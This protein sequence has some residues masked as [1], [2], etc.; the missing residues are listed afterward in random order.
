MKLAPKNLCKKLSVI[1]RVGFCKLRRCTCEC[2]S[3]E[4]KKQCEN[5]FEKCLLKT[6]VS[7]IPNAYSFFDRAINSAEKKIQEY[8]DTEDKLKIIGGLVFH[9]ETEILH[10]FFESPGDL[11]STIS[12]VNSYV[13]EDLSKISHSDIKET[14]VALKVWNLIISKESFSN[15]SARLRS[16][17]VNCY[18]NKNAVDELKDF[19]SN[20]LRAIEELETSIETRVPP[21]IEGHNFKEAYSEK[22]VPIV[23]WCLKNVN[24]VDIWDYSLHQNFSQILKHIQQ[25]GESREISPSLCYKLAYPHYAGMMHASK[26]IFSKFK[27]IQNIAK[28]NKGI[29]EEI[30][31]RE[32]TKK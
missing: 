14:A 1:N 29:H 5:G 6:D 13:K 22:M 17:D 23:E 4:Y 25:V 18:G 10:C 32:Y 19:I 24:Q 9:R 27:H 30:M 7:V 2:W 26:Y 20:P 31:A 28:L 3:C 12:T 8:F 15:Q 11:P 16:G 21:P